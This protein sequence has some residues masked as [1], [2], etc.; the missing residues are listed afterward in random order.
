M[1]RATEQRN[2]RRG[3]RGTRLSLLLLV[4]LGPTLAGLGSCTRDHDMDKVSNPIDPARTGLTPP[5]PRRVEVE[6][7]NRQVELDWSL[8]DSSLVSSVRRYR[9]YKREGEGNLVLTDSTSAPPVRVSGLSNGVRYKFS[10][11]SVLTNGMEGLRSEEIPA[12]PGVFAL[13]IENGRQSVN[14]PEIALN[15]LAPFGTSGVR[16]ANEPDDPRRAATQNFLPSLAWTLPPGDGRKTV[17][18]VFVDNDGNLSD[19]VSDAVTLDTRSEI[20]QVTLSPGEV[21]PGQTLRIELNAGEPH[22]N[23]SVQLGIGGRRLT[24]HDDDAGG[25]V[26]DDGI[27]TLDYLIEEDLVL[28]DGIVTGFFTDEAG[29]QA[30]SRV[31]ASRLTVGRPP[32]AVT[33]LTPTNVSEESVSLSWTQSLTNAFAQ[34]RIYRGVAPAVLEDP[35]ARLLGT[36]TSASQTTYEDRTELEQ[37]QTYYYMVQVVDDFGISSESNVVSATTPDKPPTA[38]SLSNPSSV[39]ENSILLSWSQNND[40]DFARYELRRSTR[41]GV[42]E[43]SLLLDT[44]GEKRSTSFLDQ[45]LTENTDYFYRVFAVDRGGNVTG[46]NEL[47]QKTQ[48]DD[49][50]AVRLQTPTEEADALTPTIHLTWT[51]STAHDFQE[52]RIY[53]DTAPAIGEASTLV[54]TVADSIVTSFIDAGLTDNT[55]Y[56]YRVFV[57]DDAGGKSGSNEQAIVTANRPPRPVTLSVGATTSTSITL[58]WTQTS[59][60][61]FNAY[62]LRRGTRSDNFPTVVETFLQKEQTSHTL[63]VAEG[64]STRY[65]FRVAVY[66]K[67]IDGEQRLRTDSN[68]VSARTAPR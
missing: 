12:V 38:V 68:V 20:T 57:F 26:A 2:A 30:P 27:Y 35:K 22:G 55:R 47:S 4:L 36:L 5:V 45:G 11:S 48:N 21:E 61:D 65:F 33:L 44:L 63:F 9:V 1:H 32:D 54:R 43:S 25:A 29:N 17:A 64:D 28:V 40:L 18:V 14:R 56:Y 16:I 3:S 34:Y 31:A 15:L 10:V 13:V 37:N 19:V 6:I 46:S 24:L 8:S 7:A 42:S 58:S 50:P 51:I 66:D 41:A 62:E 23:A 53:R 49:P 60:P 59:S 52:Y 67:A 39:G